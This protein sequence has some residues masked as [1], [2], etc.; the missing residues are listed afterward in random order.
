MILGRRQ[1]T[2]AL[3]CLPGLASPAFA[4][5]PCVF[6]TDGVAMN[7]IDPVSYFTDHRPIDG[8]D[9]Y[10]LRW[11]N[12]IWRFASY[13]TMDAFERDPQQFAPRY[14]GFCAVTMASGAVSD[15]IPIAWSVHEGRLYLARSEAAIQAWRQDP[16][17]YIARADQYWPSA[18]CG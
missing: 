4:R 6:S 11:R 12:V 15:T 17:T 8:S 13:E 16:A 9:S 5:S 1:F 10:R 2:L 3:A 14:G 7:G 18:M